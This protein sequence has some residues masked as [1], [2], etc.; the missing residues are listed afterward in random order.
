MTVSELISIVFVSIRSERTVSITQHK[1][2]QSI[3]GENDTPSEDGR[4]Q[5][6]RLG[7]KR[8]HTRDE[9]IL[10]ATLN[11]LAEVGYGGMSMDMVAAHAGAGK[12]TIYRRWSSKEALILDAVAHMKSKQVD[13]DS[14]PDTGTLRSDLLALFKPQSIE[15]SE[16][17]LK[18]MT[19]LTSMLSAQQGLADAV[20]AA[21]VEPWAAA[22]RMLMQRAVERGEIS[23]SADIETA[24]QIIPSMAAYRSLI[25]RRPFEKE[26]LV[27]LIDG[28]LLPA[29][30]NA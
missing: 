29:L 7:R 30:H 10:E 23:E 15:E 13:L 22:H 28:V 20:N 18:V 6:A 17:R 27:T 3:E 11:V 5:T 2:A 1:S 12:A 4:A 19:G 24:S 16:R 14:L 21:I 9:D 8:D 26:F 25:Q